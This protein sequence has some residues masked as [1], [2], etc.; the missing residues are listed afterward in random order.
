MDW[1]RP[2][3]AGSPKSQVVVAGAKV[4]ARSIE[5]H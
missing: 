2:D 3:V 4:F 1:L 5:S